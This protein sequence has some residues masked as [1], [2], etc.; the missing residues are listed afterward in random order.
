VKKE[1]ERVIE[2]KRFG[3]KKKEKP[4]QVEEATTD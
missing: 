3:K 1:W 2:K 4:S